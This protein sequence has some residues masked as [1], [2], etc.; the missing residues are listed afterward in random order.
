VT[1]SELLRFIVNYLTEHRWEWIEE[2]EPF[3][4]QHPDLG[5]VFS[6]LEAAKAQIQMEHAGWPPT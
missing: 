1:E 6:T 4:W 5:G 2:E 3:P